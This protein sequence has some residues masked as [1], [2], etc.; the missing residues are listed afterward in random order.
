[1]VGLGS[2]EVSTEHTAE[3]AAS[4]R[5]PEPETRDDA[6]CGSWRDERLSHPLA[7]TSFVRVN[8][9]PCCLTRKKVRRHGVVWDAAG[10]RLGPNPPPARFGGLVLYRI[11]PNIRVSEAL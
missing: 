9:I 7:P 4:G 6:R 10:L 11:F 3:D 5:P 8:P 2:A 1:M